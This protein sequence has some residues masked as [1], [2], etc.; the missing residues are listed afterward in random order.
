MKFYL[1]TTAIRS[2]S[3]AIFESDFILQLNEAYKLAN[4]CG[5]FQIECR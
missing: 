3:H 4:H 2:V 1:P 5:A